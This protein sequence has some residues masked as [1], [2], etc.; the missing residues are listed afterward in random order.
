MQHRTFHN[1]YGRASVYRLPSSHDLLLF[2]VAYFSLSFLAVPNPVFDVPTTQHSAILTYDWYHTRSSICFHS[3][4]YAL[5]LQCA[6]FCWTAH[7]YLPEFTYWMRRT[8]GTHERIDEV[9][10]LWEQP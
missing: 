9:T 2:Q 5:P 10:T 6:T 3:P 4:A 8:Y 7:G 1:E